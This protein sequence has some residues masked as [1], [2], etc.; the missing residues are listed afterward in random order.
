M[1]AVEVCDAHGT[2]KSNLYAVQLAG[3]L[4]AT[5]MSKRSKHWLGGLAIF[6]ALIAV[7]LYLF[8][9][10]MLRGPIARQVERSTGRTFA[11]NG[12]L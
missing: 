10:N 7:G 3:P 4:E 6:V 1:R 11:I 12:D 9:W 2:H 8:D 5:L